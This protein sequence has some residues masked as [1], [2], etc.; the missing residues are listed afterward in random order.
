MI[1]CQLSVF[2]H[3]AAT[4]CNFSGKFDYLLVDHHRYLVHGLLEGLPCQLD[5]RETG[6]VF[7][8]S[9]MK[10]A[11]T[12][13]DVMNGGHNISNSPN[14]ANHQDTR[15]MLQWG[16]EKGLLCMLLA[17][18]KCSGI[19]VGIGVESCWDTE[20]IPRIIALMSMHMVVGHV[21]LLSIQRNLHAISHHKIP[22]RGIPWGNKVIKGP[23]SVCGQRAGAIESS[24]RGLPRGVDPRVFLQ[25]HCR[26]H[27]C[28]WQF[29]ELGM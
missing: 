14:A 26:R 15:L 17:F 19:T 1:I 13:V 2:A 21:P 27:H 28:L 7:G 8:L 4:G 18:L 3:I 24:G 20:N 25:P 10:Q 23:C 29:L 11:N 22:R 16:G 6:K 12:I 9:V 5:C